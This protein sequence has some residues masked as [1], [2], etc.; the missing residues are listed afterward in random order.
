MPIYGTEVDWYYR[1]NSFAVVM[2]FGTHQRKPTLEEIKFEYNRTNDAF[3]Y[4][5]EKAPTTKLDPNRLPIQALK[6]KNIDETFRD[7]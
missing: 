1:N 2:E 5:L 3:L 4:F 7:E 6:P